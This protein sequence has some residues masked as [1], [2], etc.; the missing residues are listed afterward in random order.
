M[1][2]LLDLLEA[3][4]GGAGWLRF[5]PEEPEPVSIADLWRAAASSARWLSRR[6]DGGSAVAMVLGSSSA[7]VSALFGAWRA[8]HDDGDFAVRLAELYAEFT[9]LSDEATDLRRKVDRVVRGIL[10]P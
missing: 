1:R 2:D 6:L 4:A 10:E 3:A 7:A 5:L 8:G 9:T